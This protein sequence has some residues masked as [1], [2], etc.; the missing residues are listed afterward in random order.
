MCLRDSPYQVYL[1]NAA[2]KDRRHPDDAVRRDQQDAPQVLQGFF[3]KVG[4]AQ[5]GGDYKSD[6]TDRQE[7]GRCV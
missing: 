3:P 7:G 1:R 2:G 6:Q 5:D 4:P